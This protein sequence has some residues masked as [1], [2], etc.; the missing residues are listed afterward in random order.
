MKKPVKWAIFIIGFLVLLLIGFSIFIKTFLSGDRLKA[1]IL[2]RAESMT[3]R[4]VSLDEI[5]ISLFKGIVAKGLSVKE[6][7]GQGDFLK[8]S[9]FILS[10]RFLPL[11]K[12]E[13]VISKM[14]ITS[15][16]I[17]V[18]KHKEG[19]YNFSD[20]LEK[21]P[22]ASPKPHEP[23]RQGLPVSLITDKLL[24]R[25]AQFTFVDEEKALPNI[26]GNL[27]MEF[28]G[29]IGKEGVPHLE[30]GLISL[31]EIKIQMKDIE[32]KTTGKVEIDPKVV[33][34]N[35]QA[36][37]GKEN[38]EITATVKDY[39]SAPDVIGNI[40]ARSLDLE[41]LIAMGGEKKTSEERPP[42]KEQRTGKAGES[43]PQ[44]EQKAGKVA[45]SSIQKIKAKG[46]ITVD[47]A[48]YQDYKIKDLRLDYS[49]V[50]GMLKLEPLGLKFSGGDAFTM[51]G[52]LNGNLQLTV[53]EVSTIQKSLRGK[54]V[55]KLGK[56]QIKESKI[57]DA[58][59]LLIGVPELKKPEIEEGLLNFDIKDEKVNLDGLIQSSLFKLTPKGTVDFEKRLDILP[60]LK[61]S[62]NL[63]GR[64]S[65][66]LTA[67]KFM[68][69]EQGWKT[70]PIKIKGTTEKPNVTLD[71]EA[72]KKQLGSGLKRGFEKLIQGRTPEEEG[73]PSKK[74]TPKDLL[75][76]LFG[77]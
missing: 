31:K 52:T 44:K 72:L 70:I 45:E 32:V 4:K 47:E 5:N 16:F 63:T 74:G 60:G 75:K 51:E 29:G 35:L 30:K 14:E 33:Q 20:L 3:G 28:R 26:S 11:L 17:S 10:Y 9:E 42:Q 54:A 48:K 13:L 25:N 37:I 62:P 6:K 71:E 57:F 27:D 40:H 73:K 39:L 12:R 23:A 18:K 49:Y 53:D 68:E 77:K 21:H 76:E 38:I 65:K 7:D 2:P 41:R 66:S 8:I 36:L 69:D 64:L 15:P 59:A 67:I 61:I 22:P 58:I 50:R 46:R 55:V 43:F 34:A 56:G 1:I 19:R 24:I